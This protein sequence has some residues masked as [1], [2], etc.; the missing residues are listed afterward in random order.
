MSDKPIEELVSL[1]TALEQGRKPFESVWDE[2]TDLYYTK[3][4]I[5]APKNPNASKKPDHR[6]S[7]KAKRASSIA[8]RGFQG[9][10][11]DRRSDWM[12]L[13]FED[14]ALMAMYGVQDW[15]EECH[16][17]LSAHFSRAGLYEAL[18]ELIPDGHNLGTGAIY[19]EEITS[20]ARIAYRCKH[21]WACYF[22]ENSFGEIDI[23]RDEE[24]MSYRSAV[25]RFGKEKLHE[26]WQRNFESR[27]LD[28][29]LIQHITMPMDERYLEYAK[30]PIIRS[31]PFVSIWLDLENQHIIDVGGFW[32]FP[33]FVWRYERSAGDAYGFGPGFDVID[34]CYVA[35]QMTRSRIAL[36][37]LIADPPLLIPEA[38]EGRDQVVPGHHIYT[39][40]SEQQIQPLPIGANYPITVDN[41]ERIEA[42]IDAHFNVGI[43]QML[44]QMEARNKTATEV[45]EMAGERVAVLGPTVGGYE[46][47]V[48]QPA[49]RRSFQMLMRS[50][51]LP[52]PPQV[53]KEAIKAGQVL[54]VEFMGRLS[55]ISKRYYK[56]DG[57]NQALGIAGALVQLYPDALDNIDFDQLTREGLENAGAPASVI[58]EKEDVAKIRQDRLAQQ[59]AIAQ[60][61][62]Q[63][64]A[65]QMMISNLDKLGRAPEPGSPAASTGGLV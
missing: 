45:I 55:Q 33:Y 38:L 25:E 58:R 60:K 30:G 62:E 54:K 52:E 39:T 32:E 22:A 17:T 49:V 7:S 13:Q 5:Y 56:S 14:Q 18:A 41:E 59:Q 6:Y 27:P 10:T 48:L 19:S 40:A 34:D 35:N 36:G 23:A 64:A 50:G 42:A 46:N 4:R 28:N 9:Y 47:Q 20:K 43:Y 2:I 16:R 3:R 57:T 65:Q 26:S 21:P 63:A 24:W 61:Q 29:V 53:V 8:S 15:L 51:Q 37:N 12:L 11:A 31:F 44:E 1:C